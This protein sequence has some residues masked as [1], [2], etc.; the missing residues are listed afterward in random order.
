MSALILNV[1]PISVLARW[2]I[3][4]FH[5]NK[6]G[7]VSASL[8]LS[9]CVVALGLVMLQHGKEANEGVGGFSY[10]E[11]SDWE[12]FGVA[13][14]FIA[15]IFM[16]NTVMIGFFMIFFMIFW[17]VT[18]RI[19]HRHVSG[20]AGYQIVGSMLWVNLV[21]TWTLFAT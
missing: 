6:A 13:V 2:P 9:W 12:K 8:C 4:C 7:V 20:E 18:F 15:D 14:V 11:S 5:L 3:G 10:K 19:G 16:A 21:V 17:I 1:G